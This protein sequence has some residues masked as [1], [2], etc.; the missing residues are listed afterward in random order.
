MGLSV[1]GPGTEGVPVVCRVPLYS[2]VASGLRL[3]SFTGS[4]GFGTLGRGCGEREI[5][6]LTFG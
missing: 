5:E 2:L 1:I 6:A 3:S 4:L